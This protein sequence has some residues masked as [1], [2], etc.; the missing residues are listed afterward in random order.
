MKYM[1]NHILEKRFFL[2]RA[3][4]MDALVFLLSTIVD[5]EVVGTLQIGYPHA[6]DLSSAPRRQTAHPAGEGSDVAACPRS[7]RPAPGAR[8]LWHRHMPH[9][10]KH[11]TR[12][13]R[14][15]VSPCV[16][17]LQ[18]RLSV[19]RASASPCA[20]WRRPTT[21]QG[22]APESPCVSRLQACP[23]RG[24]ALASLQV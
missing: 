4:N 10:I 17:L 21:Q 9:G 22:R 1:S 19:Q 16:L 24:K 13:E 5:A 7:S 14:A 3:S 15:P 11:A 6:Q 8:E 23:L 18:T 12:Q 2:Y 20:P